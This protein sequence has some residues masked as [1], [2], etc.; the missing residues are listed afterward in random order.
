LVNVVQVQEPVIKIDK[1][2]AKCKQSICCTSINQKV[3]APR[4]LEDFDH[5]LWQVSHENINIFKDADGWFL[6][7][8]SRCQHLR[9]GGICAIYETR[10]FVCRVY[11]NDHCEYDSPIPEAA[12]M[13]FS[14]HEEFEKYCRQR[15]SQWDN[16]F[17]KRGY[18]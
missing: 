12:E 1:K 17:K 16:R 18:V 6:H 11:T 10:P 9:D 15:F 3:D 8:H 4:S 5:L 7:I 2:C 14:N 13:F